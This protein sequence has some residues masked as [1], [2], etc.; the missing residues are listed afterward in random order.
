MPVPIVRFAR[1]TDDLDALALQYREGLGLSELG[2]FTDHAG[3]DGVMLG[4][5]G[6]GWHLEFTHERGQRAGG[7][8]SPEHLFVLYV[9]DADDWRSRCER[10]LAAGFEEV[11]AHNP[12]W[13]DRGRTFVDRDG[14]R[15]VLANAVWQR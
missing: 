3:F 15:V 4:H 14:Y 10:A 1:P 8:A 11:S 2:H 13:A 12:Y 9:P 5:P 6:Q 7:A